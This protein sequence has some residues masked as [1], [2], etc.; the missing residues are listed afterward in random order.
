MLPATVATIQFM[1][2]NI[3]LS[4]NLRLKETSIY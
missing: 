3:F 4:T 1:D 2:F